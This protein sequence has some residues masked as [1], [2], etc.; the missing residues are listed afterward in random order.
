[1]P[2]DLQG[3]VWSVLGAGGGAA[4]IAY[5][6]FKQLGESWLDAR[7]SERLEAF[8]HEKAAELEKLRAEIDGTLRAKIRHQEK[9]FIVLSECWDLMNVAFGAAHSLISPLQQYQDVGRMSDEMCREYLDGIEML[10]SQRI[11]ILQ[12]SNRMR[13]FTR[14]YDYVKLNR[15][16]SAVMEFNNCIFR[17]EIFIDDDITTDFTSMVRSLRSAIDDK[18]LSRHLNDPGLGSKAWQEIEDVASPKIIEIAAKLRSRIR[19]QKTAS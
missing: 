1:M 13:E 18:A 9:E 3:F 11:E 10:E 15:A 5:L 16:N 17:N 19:N 6:L 7:F 2:F 12:S 8:R 4:V 14:V